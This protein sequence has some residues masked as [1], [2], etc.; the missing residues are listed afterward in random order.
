[1]LI[2]S[3]SPLPTFG[4]HCKSLVDQALVVQTF[5]LILTSVFFRQ[6]RHILFT[7]PA[8]THAGA[9]A[10]LDGPGFELVK[11]WKLPNMRMLYWHACVLCVA[12][13]TTGYD[14]SVLVL[15]EPRDHL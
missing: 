6:L 5:T 10:N 3:I 14:G 7:M 4:T 1:M 12:S 2:I 11:W 15:G 8:M 9:G 13:A